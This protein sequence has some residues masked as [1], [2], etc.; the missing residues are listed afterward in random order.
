M[1]NSVVVNPAA[2]V[3]V[4]SVGLLLEE[5]TQLSEAD[6]LMIPEFNRLFSSP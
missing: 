6:T 2:E 4:A 1:L 3:S 5:E